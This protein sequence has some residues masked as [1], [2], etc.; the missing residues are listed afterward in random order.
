MLSTEKKACALL[1]PV[2]PPTPVTAGVTVSCLMVMLYSTPTV[3]E[4]S[5]TSK[6]TVGINFSVITPKTMVKYYSKPKEVPRLYLSKE[7]CE[8]LKT[9]VV[10][11]GE[12]L[13]KLISSLL[14]KV[15]VGTKSL[16]QLYF[17]GYSLAAIA[18]RKGISQDQVEAI[19]RM[20]DLL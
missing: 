14:T 4:H 18:K 15:H 8:E 13:V 2:V 17:D 19:L 20:N 9:R 1:A 16:A 10:S 11:W 3:R 6:A 7:T 12:V 5:S